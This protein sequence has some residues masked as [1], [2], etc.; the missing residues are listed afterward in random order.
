MAVPIRL[1]GV[2]FSGSPSDLSAPCAPKGVEHTRKKIG[3]TVEGIDGTANYFHRAHKRGWVIAWED[4]PMATVTEVETI[5]LL[6]TTF[7]YRD[8][9]GVALTV[10]CDSRDDMVSSISS[11]SGD[12]TA[13]Y[14]ITLAIWLP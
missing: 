1:N 4:A 2:I 9:N 14:N 10:Q 7:T 3:P 8:E 13:Y 5:F 6:T 12:G 11:I